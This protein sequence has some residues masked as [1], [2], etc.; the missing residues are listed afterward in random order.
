MIRNLLT[1]ALAL[2]LGGCCACLPLKVAPI[3]PVPFEEADQDER[4]DPLNGT[5]STNGGTT[6]TNGGPPGEEAG[7]NNRGHGNG[8][9][10]SDP[11]DNGTDNTDADN[12]GRGGERGKK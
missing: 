4:S 6:S 11:A 3:I 9:E 10:N 12:P 2:I 8:N 5:T 1:G 7:R